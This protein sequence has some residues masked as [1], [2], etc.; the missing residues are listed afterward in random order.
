V[1]AKDFVLIK[2][3]TFAKIAL[4]RFGIVCLN[5]IFSFLLSYVFSMPMKIDYCKAKLFGLLK[6]ANKVNPFQQSRK[7]ATVVPRNNQ[8]SAFSGALR[9]SNSNCT[10]LVIII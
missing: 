2:I 3:C 5:K 4:C 9:I 10:V 7:G 8:L 6:K 1:D